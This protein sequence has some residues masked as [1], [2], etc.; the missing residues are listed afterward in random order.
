MM[1][2]GSDLKNIIFCEK[3]KKLVKL[4][5]SPFILYLWIRNPDPRTQMNMD[6]TGSGS[7]LL[8]FILYEKLFNIYKF[9]FTVYRSYGRHSVLTK[10]LSEPYPAAHQHPGRS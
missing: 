8:H 5:F 7:T 4:V 2:L 3:K 9:Y 1:S 6:P 10:Y